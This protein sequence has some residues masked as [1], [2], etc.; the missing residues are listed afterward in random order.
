MRWFPGD[1][2]RDTM[3]LTRCEHGSYRLLIDAM[4]S[5][6]GKLPNDEVRL[7]RLAMCSP[8]EWAECRETI[9][10]FFQVRGAHLT[11]KRI[12]REMGH[13]KVVSR[14][15]Q[16]AGK[17]GGAVSTGKRSRSSQAIGEQLPSK[18]RHN[19]NQNQSPIEA[20]LKGASN[21]TRERPILLVNGKSEFTPEE[22]RAQILREA[23]EMNLVQKL[24]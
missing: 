2:A 4:W 5:A 18:S 3:H 16:L 1:Y 9:L 6:G 19:Q 12:A 20:P 23:E 8:E 13:Y 11:Q 24:G 14:K 15:R 22:L 7:A 10:G 17:M 21:R